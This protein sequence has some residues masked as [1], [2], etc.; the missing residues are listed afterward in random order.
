MT[1]GPE[2]VQVWTAVGHG[3]G[4]SP[5]AGATAEQQAWMLPSGVFRVSERL[6]ARPVF[7]STLN[8]SHPGKEGSAGLRGRAGSTGVTGRRVSVSV[9][10][11]L[12]F[13]LQ[14]H[15]LFSILLAN[16]YL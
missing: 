10:P 1:S 13:K 3:G 8:A 15:Y 11:L 9:S 2:P 16:L 7:L 12:P 6:T 14:A 5:P 4:L